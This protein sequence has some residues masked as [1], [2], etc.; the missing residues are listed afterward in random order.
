M[1]ENYTNLI[2][3]NVNDHTCMPANTDDAKEC[4]SRTF[5]KLL[6]GTTF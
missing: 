2:A 4:A 6:V 3:K 5:C 1:D